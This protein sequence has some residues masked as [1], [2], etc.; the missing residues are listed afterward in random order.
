MSAKVQWVSQTIMLAVKEI[1]CPKGCVKHA[2]IVKN[3]GLTSRQVADACAKLA[4]HGYLKREEYSDNTVKPGCY[5]LTPLAHTA[6]DEGVKFTSGPKGPTGK[7]RPRPD[8]LRDRAW[9]LLRI[10]RKASVPEIVGVLMDAGSNSAD[11]KRAENNLSKYFRQLM[12]AGYVTEMRREA[13]DSPTS[14]GA[15]RFFL[16]RDTGLLSPI[17]KT[18]QAAVYDQNEGKLYATS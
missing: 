17:P 8:G 16:A 1:A 7:T 11:I 10:R 4:E 5:R 12:R 3:T 13:P 15:K 14:N 6:L 2:A 9:R 18:A